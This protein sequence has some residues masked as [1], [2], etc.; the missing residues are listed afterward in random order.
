MGRY[1]AERLGICYASVAAA[2]GLGY[3]LPSRVSAAVLIEPVDRLDVTVMG[4]WVGWAVFTDYELEISDIAA[5]N[6]D[7]ADPEGLAATLEKSRL[8]AR[9]A[10]NTGWGGLDVKGEVTDHLLLG[11][12]IVFD[13]AAIPDHAVSSN[14][15]DANDLMLS[16]LVA[17]K[18]I[19]QVQVGL[20]Y[21]YHMLAQRVVTDSGWGVTVEEGPLKEDRWFYP[22]ANGTYNGVIHRAGLQVRTEFGKRSE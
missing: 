22:H 13:H 16:G 8:R 20:S 12:R 21:T 18:P 3:Q 17:A 14:N 4:G 6:P 2:G 1:G 9:D 15:Y 11:G 19:P 10:R 7:Q 5:R